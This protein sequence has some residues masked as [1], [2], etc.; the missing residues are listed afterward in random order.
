[1]SGTLTLII[2]DNASVAYVELLEGQS[3]YVSPGKAHRLCAGDS[4]V[5]IFEV[6]TPELDDVVRLADNYK[7][8]TIGKEYNN[9]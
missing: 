7:R 3:A 9:G 8:T 5:K 6:S 1:M 2:E 4:G